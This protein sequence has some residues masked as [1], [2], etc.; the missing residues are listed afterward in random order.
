MTTQ[1]RGPV[2]LI[3]V[4]TPK[5]GMMDA[6]IAAQLDGLPALGQ[7]AG[8]LSS[9]LYRAADDRNAIL[10][11]FFEDEDA[12]RRFAESAAFQAHRQRLLPLLEGASPG[13]YTLVYARGANP[14]HVG[15]PE[16]AAA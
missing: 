7:I 9:R 16:T 12:Q 13:F 2:A 6:F 10:I 14:S 8:S 3:N 5:P 15:A 11:G 4:F 1:T